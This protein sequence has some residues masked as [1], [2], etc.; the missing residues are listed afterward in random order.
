MIVSMRV[1][2]I[3]GL[4]RQYYAAWRRRIAL[5]DILHR[6]PLWHFRAYRRRHEMWARAVRQTAQVTRIVTA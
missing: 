6:T 4:E 3:A 1:V 5:F 2:P